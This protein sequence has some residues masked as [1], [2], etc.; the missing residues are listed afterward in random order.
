MEE[1]GQGSLDHQIGIMQADSVCR[2][3]TNVHRLTAVGSRF[4]DVSTFDYSFIQVY[5]NNILAFALFLIQ[6]AKPL[7]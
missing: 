5:S 2:A 1:R 7:A 4:P 6:N 3:S